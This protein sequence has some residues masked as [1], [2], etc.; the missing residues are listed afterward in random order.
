MVPNY[1]KAKGVRSLASLQAHRIGVFR[2]GFSVA[3]GG[4]R[5]I[6]FLVFCSLP[7]NRSVYIVVSARL[8]LRVPDLREPAIQADLDPCCGLLFWGNSDLL[9]MEYYCAQHIQ[10]NELSFALKQVF[11]LQAILTQGPILVPQDSKVRVGRIYNSASP[12][13]TLNPSTLQLYKPFL[14]SGF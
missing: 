7:K 1:D 2:G 12:T 8:S 9:I 10:H 5:L 3:W 14:H 13:E 6:G 11:S 4:R